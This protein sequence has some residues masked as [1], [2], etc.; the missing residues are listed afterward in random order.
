MRIKRKILAIVFLLL[1]CYPII[2]ANVEGTIEVTA[3]DPF[4]S[5]TILCPNT[6]PERMEWALTITNEFEKI[7]IDVTLI[8]ESWGGISPRT[9]GYPGPYPI[10]LYSAGGYDVLVVGWNF[11][12]ESDPYNLYHSDKIPPNG[13]N[14]YQYDN[15][16]VDTYIDNYM[17][18]I[19]ASNKQFWADKIQEVLYDE[20][21]ALNVVYDSDLYGHD[22]NLI[23]WDPVLW[24]NDEQSME[25]WAIPGETVFNYASPQNFEDFLIHHTENTLDEQWLSQIYCGL[26]SRYAR[27]GNDFGPTIASSWVTDDG[28]NYTV[29]LNP[30]AKWADGTF[31][32]SSDID[33]NYDLII[34]TDYLSPMYAYWSRYVDSDSVTIIDSDTFNI[35]FLEPYI[36]QEKNLGLPLIPEHIWSPI[37]PA[38]MQGQ[39]ST[40]AL[41]DPSK[42]F[43][44]GPYKLV[45]YNPG[46]SYIHLDRNPYYHYATGIT[47]NFEDVYFRLESTTFWATTYLDDG[48]YD[49]IDASYGIDIE[50]IN[51]NSS[52]S[53]VEEGYQELAINQEHPYIGTGSSCPIA[54][55]QSA[56]Y[57]RKAMSHAIPRQAIIEDALDGLGIPGINNWMVNS[58][59]YNDSYSAYEY[60][61]TKAKEYLL[62]AGFEVNLDSDGDGVTDY[63]EINT[64]LTDPYDVDSDDDGVSDG[65]EILSIFTDPLDSDTDNDGLTDGEE[66]TTGLD[67][68]ITNPSDA[69]TDDDNLS[70]GYELILGTD[71]TDTDSDSDGMDDNWEFHNSTN[72]LVDD[73]ALDPDEDGL[74]NLEEYN[75]GTYPFDDDSDND[76]SSDGVEVEAGTDPLDPNDTPTTEAN[77]FTYIPIVFVSLISILIITIRRRKK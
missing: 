32:D 40:W 68:V 69:D 10:P 67:G 3:P 36:F 1:L 2:T 45:E 23:N 11:D 64:Y 15:P 76:G 25:D 9:W 41:S 43:G 24:D 51:S 5:I 75:E 71:P 30:N 63:D 59:H 13:D 16:V 50:D 54:G 4:F 37:A 48:T 73:S 44:C 49:M 21:P 7:G 20:L 8:Y 18:S 14:F 57:V 46:Q 66:Y 70:D 35:S 55:P 27:F 52:Y 60:N 26:G 12:L 34:D 38:A 29:E 28:L 19:T 39:A 33:F 47:P 42:L 53:L 6:S 58:L 74:T 56:I 72:P 65:I 31:I 77:G 17:T 62:L 61:L 22:S